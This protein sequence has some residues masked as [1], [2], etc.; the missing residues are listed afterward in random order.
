LNRLKLISLGL[1]GTMFVTFWGFGCATIAGLDEEFQHAPECNP[2]VAPAAPSVQNA[3]DSI[4]FSTTIRTVDLDEEDDVPR[5]GYDLDGKCSC[6]VDG[7]SCTRPNFVDP[8]KETCDDARGLDNGAG[9]A[10]SRVSTLAAG[11][12][13]SIVVNEGANQGL[14]S[15]IIRVR[16]YSGMPND[17]HVKVA[18]YETPGLMKPNWDGLDTWPISKATVGPSGTI[19]D[20]VNFDDKAYVHDGILVARI[21]KGR[22]VLRAPTAHLP[23]DLVD[24]IL[25]AKITPGSGGNW[26]LVEGTLAGKWSLPALFKDLSQ[27][28]YGSDVMKKLCRDDI[29]YLQVKNLFCSAT[30]ILDAATAAGQTECNAISFGMRFDTE[31]I[32]LGAVADP[33]P[34][35]P[36]ECDP[37]Y[38]PTSDTCMKVQ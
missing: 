15:L 32:Q 16:D 17:D 34:D 33:L 38:D 11:S 9:I 19:D 25:S 21:P 31:S 8:K 20:P 3:G 18:I 13:S 10:L 6:T 30:D 28:R 37:G 22:L 12:I 1:V 2:T 29:L 26:R 23:I 4:E 27:F 35:P 5:F 36:P 7:P 24:L 14:W